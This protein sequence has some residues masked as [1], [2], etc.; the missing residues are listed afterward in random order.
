MRIRVARLVVPSLNVT[1][2][3]A[4]GVP[5]PGATALTVAVKVTD[6]PNTVGLVEELMVVVV[7]AA[8]TVWVNGEAVL[9][10]ALK[11]LSPL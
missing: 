9:S 3:P 2:V 11:L 7:L 5:L 4:G 6:W 8:L 1:V 10:L